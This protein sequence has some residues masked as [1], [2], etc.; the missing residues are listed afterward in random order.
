MNTKKIIFHYIIVF[1]LFFSCKKEK[2]NLVVNNKE[3]D[4]AMLDT[5]SFSTH[6]G[7]YEVRNLFSSTQL[8]PLETNKQSLIGS[9]RKIIYK[10][11]YI[12]I[13]DETTG[14]N[15]ILVF[16]LK[17]KFITAIRNTGRGPGEYNSIIDFTVDEKGLIYILHDSCKKILVYSADG[18]YQKDIK[19]KVYIYG[20]EIFN[21]KIYGYNGGGSDNLNPNKHIVFIFNAEGKLIKG[22]FPASEGRKLTSSNNIFSCKEDKMYINIPFYNTIYS[23]NKKDEIKA[24][25]ALEYTIKS[26]KGKSINLLE[27]DPFKKVYFFKNTLLFIT[28]KGGYFRIGIRKNDE[29]N[30]NAIPFGTFNSNIGEGIIIDAI[31]AIGGAVMGDS[32]IINVFAPF[33]LKKNY[34]GL[35][36]DDFLKNAPEQLIK[37]IKNLDEQSNPVLLLNTLQKDVIIPNDE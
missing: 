29:K 22:A 18:I 35:Q 24:E 7:K 33:H 11:D 23:I 31:P 12:Y 14:N 9:V 4:Y 15:S 20:F 5:I 8:I 1:F 30:G 32:T 19:L 16:D 21:N 28:S 3:I 27:K 6:K 2:E 36:K 13:F 37:T 26:K 17:G 25:H 10:K 34:L